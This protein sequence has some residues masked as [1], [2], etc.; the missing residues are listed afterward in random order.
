M[1]RTNSF[2]RIIMRRTNSFKRI[3]MRRTN[4]FKIVERFR[5]EKTDKIILIITK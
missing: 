1:R 3:I 5:I 2:K 4:S